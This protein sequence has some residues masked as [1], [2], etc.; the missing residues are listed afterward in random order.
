MNSDNVEF[1]LAM[2]DKLQECNNI[3]RKH[4]N[5]PNLSA[6]GA[7]VGTTLAFMI[8]VMDS[9]SQR[10]I[11]LEDAAYDRAAWRE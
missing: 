10:I 8:Q 4:S 6:W 9:M 1:W 11:V 2:N 7:E 3:L 5:Q